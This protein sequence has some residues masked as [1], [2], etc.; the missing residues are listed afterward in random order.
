MFYGA[1]VYRIAHSHY[2]S[3]TR[4]VVGVDINPK[5]VDTVNKD[6]FIVEPVCRSCVDRWFR[7]ANSK[8]RFIPKQATFI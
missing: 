2:C 5:V 3:P 6:A 4:H 7:K 1:G 8:P